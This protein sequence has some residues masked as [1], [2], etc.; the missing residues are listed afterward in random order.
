MSENVTYAQLLHIAHINA[1]AT[2][3]AALIESKTID[4]SSVHFADG[5]KAVAQPSIKK[6]R[7]AVNVVMSTVG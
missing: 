7:D 1:R 5:A 2:I 4:I 6:L 3:A